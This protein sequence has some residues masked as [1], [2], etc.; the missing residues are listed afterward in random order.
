MPVES[1]QPAPSLV[2]EKLTQAQSVSEFDCFNVTL[3]TWLNVLPGPINRA[4]SQSKS[5]L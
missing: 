2:I 4:E 1:N 3:N 5:S